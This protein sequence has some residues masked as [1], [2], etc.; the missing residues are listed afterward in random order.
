MLSITSSGMG[1]ALVKGISALIY[2][3]SIIS[4]VLA[5]FALN[6]HG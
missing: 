1:R 4:V 3:S 2:F 5:G 6:G